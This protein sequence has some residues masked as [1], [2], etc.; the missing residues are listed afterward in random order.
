MDIREARNCKMSKTLLLVILILTAHSMSGQFTFNRIYGIEGSPL[1]FRTVNLNNNAYVLSGTY[2]D[3][4][5]EFYGMAL[6]KLNGVGDEL[7][8]NLFGSSSQGFLSIGHTMSYLSSIYLHLCTAPSASRISWINE[9]LDTI[10]VLDYIS[11]YF[12][13]PYEYSNVIQTLYGVL[14]PDSTVYLANIVIG[15]TTYNDASLQKL[16]KY[17]N[18]LWIYNHAT[19]SDPEIIKGIVPIGNDVIVGIFEEGSLQDDADHVISKIGQ[20]GIELWSLS[21]DDF[22]EGT[23]LLGTIVLD[24]NCVVVS[25]SF[26]EPGLQDVYSIPSVYKVDTLGNLIWHTTFGE[27]DDYAHRDFNNIVQTTDSNYVVSGSWRTIPGSDEI[28]EGFSGVD[29]DEFA[30]VVKFDREDGSIIWDRKYRWLEVYRDNHTLRDMKATP[31]G[32][33]I[34]C[35]EVQDLYM[36]QFE[37]FSQRGWV[38][39]LDECG[40]LVPGCDTTCTDIAVYEQNNILPIRVYPNPA[41]EILNIHVGQYALGNHAELHL[42][43]A[44]GKFI[45]SHNV[46]EN[47]TTYMTSVADLPAGSYIMQ[48]VSD[49]A[50][51]AAGKVVVE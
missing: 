20:D 34:F 1:T 45:S 44:A 40:C 15:E 14:S 31:D 46:P 6:M 26:E 50:V 21:S 23:G 8:Y 33:V 37:D 30:Y 38:V 11:P 25:G 5:E 13:E 43:D 29:Y 28:P 19:M 27:Y 12:G 48:L 16:D 36:Q 47:N 32:G 39:K 22:L 17:G 24:D 10:Q 42:I 51:I 3:T 41:S 18:T 7:D 9:S 2:T 35:G 4:T 49:G